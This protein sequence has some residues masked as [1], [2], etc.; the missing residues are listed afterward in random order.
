[1]LIP[2][3]FVLLDWSFDPWG[4]SLMFNPII[5]ESMIIR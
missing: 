1:V 4:I 5:N 2:V 3:D